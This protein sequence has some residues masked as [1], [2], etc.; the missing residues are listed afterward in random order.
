MSFNAG[1]FAYAARDAALLK[2][3]KRKGGDARDRKP[4]REMGALSP[5]VADGGDD[6]VYVEN[7]L[8]IWWRLNVLGLI[9]RLF[10]RVSFKDKNIFAVILFVVTEHSSITRDDVAKIAG[11]TESTISRWISGD[12][13]PNVLTRKALLEELLEILLREFIDCIEAF[14]E[15]PPEYSTPIS[16]LSG[17]HGDVRYD[18]TG[19]NING[20]I[21]CLS[22]FT[23]SDQRIQQRIGDAISEIKR[24]WPDDPAAT[25]TELG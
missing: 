6:S 8:T 4:A 24:K 16:I 22:V 3:K 14:R 9:L 5:F 15:L 17:I 21:E 23:E 2:K 1:N 20:V 18:D 12:R 13:Y 7:T 11:V 10:A 19:N 25:M